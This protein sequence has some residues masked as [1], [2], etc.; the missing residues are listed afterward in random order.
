MAREGLSPGRDE[1]GFELIP[2]E[3]G[4]ALRAGRLV[5]KHRDPFDR[6]LA[7]QALAMDIPIA[8]VDANLDSFGVR[9]IW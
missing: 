9:R 6:M 5:G 7:A 4:Q 3:V 2:I 1:A 8:S